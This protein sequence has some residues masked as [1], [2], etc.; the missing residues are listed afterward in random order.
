MQVFSLL[1]SNIEVE[2]SFEFFDSLCF[3]GGEAGFPLI[4]ENYGLE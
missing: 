1:F 2:N 3:T 4:E